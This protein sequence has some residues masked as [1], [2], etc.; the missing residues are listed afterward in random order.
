MHI[1]ILMTV[2]LTVAGS[3][4]VADN[5]A[6]HLPAVVM[7]VKKSRTQE[8]LERLLP[9]TV[10]KLIAEK[11]DYPYTLAA[12]AHV[13]SRGD[14]RAIG[15]SGSDKGLFQVMEKY[16]GPVNLESIESQ[17][18]QANGLFLKLVESY[19]Y[20]QAIARWNGSPN[21]PKVKRYQRIVLAKVEQLS[22]DMSLESRK[23]R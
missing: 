17:V 15:S 14:H 3:N 20:R 16:H 6:D 5:S 9:E 21:N 18:K 7:A 10:A 4:L 13:E 2:L 19:G 8:R 11:S 12:I 23:A 1:S 22:A